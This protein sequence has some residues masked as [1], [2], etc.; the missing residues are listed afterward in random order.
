MT[1]KDAGRYAKKHPKGT[2]V[3]QKVEQAIKSEIKDRKISC[4]KA[5]AI[6]DKLNTSS[7]SV[8]IAKNLVAK[9]FIKS[10]LYSTENIQIN[11]YF[12]NNFEENLFLDFGG[13]KK[14]TRE[15][16]LNEFSPE[17]KNF[18]VCKEDMA[19]HSGSFLQISRY[20]SR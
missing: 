2:S 17:K 19:P 18:L 5:H 10:I 12:S 8:G 4:S 20:F 14:K 7:K 3:P 11:L 9:K 16:I 1:H 15:K 13:G 6:I